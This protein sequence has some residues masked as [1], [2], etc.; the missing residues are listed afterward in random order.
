MGPFLLS[1][2]FGEMLLCR[3][4][5]LVGSISVLCVVVPV[6]TFV[7]VLRLHGI[8]RHKLNMKVILLICGYGSL[9][10]ANILILLVNIH[11]FKDTIL[12]LD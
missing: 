10:V 12:L 5:W 11:F 3:P 7:S 6:A 2:E 4:L 8:D 9:T 1:D